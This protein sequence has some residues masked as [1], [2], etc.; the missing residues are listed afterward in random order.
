MP[1]HEVIKADNLVIL[2]K[3]YLNEIGADESGTAGD[4]NAGVKNFALHKFSLSWGTLSLF[5]FKGSG[6][7]LVEESRGGG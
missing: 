5:K 6:K 3:E 2:L 4:E 1:R 7:T